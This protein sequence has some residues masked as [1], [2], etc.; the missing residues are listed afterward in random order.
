MLL[1]NITQNSAKLKNYCYTFKLDLGASI[2]PLQYIAV[3]KLVK[4]DNSQEKNLESGE[5]L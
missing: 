1:K 5:D 4:T 3:V 2:A